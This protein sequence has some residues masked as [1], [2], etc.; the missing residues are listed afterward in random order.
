MEGIHPIGM[1][2]KKTGLSTHTIRAWERRYQ[3][4][5]PGRSDGNQR[6]YAD[7]DIRRL[8]LLA[9]AVNEGASISRIA[10]LSEKELT[11]LISVNKPSTVQSGLLNSESDMI[12]DSVANALRHIE[13]HN[14]DYLGKELTSWLMSF[15]IIPVIERLVPALMTAIGDGW[16]GGTVRIHQEHMATCVVRDFL[17]RMMDDVGPPAA[18]ATAITATPPGEIHE[19][20]ALLCALAAKV[21]GYNV[22]HLGA[23]V[24]FPEII[25]LAY[26][27][28][29]EAI[30]LSI[31]YSA[32][33]DQLVQ[34][35]RSLREMILP[36]TKLFIG[37][38]AASWYG[39]QVSDTD[40][41]V[42]SSIAELRERLKGL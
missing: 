10:G 21:E 34:G 18:R 38:R 14:G 19:I 1:V 24:P 2:V 6:L 30:L 37:G 36:E 12:A 20:G 41:A 29:T 33:S 9:A 23:D 35:L 31:I 22:M 40:I 16:N 42:I 8:S 27:R 13:S 3:A 28:K 32:R 39:E 5:N 11:T 17:G 7:A 15:G 25:H 26:Q 4:I